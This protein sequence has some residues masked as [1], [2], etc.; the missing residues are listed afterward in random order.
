VNFFPEKEARPISIPT[1]Q[2]EVCSFFTVAHADLIGSKRRKEIVFPRHIAMFLCQELT[3]SSLPQIGKA[4][5]GKD[6]TT[7]MHAVDKIKQKIETET[8]I[9]DQV[10][11]LTKALKNKNR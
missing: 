10:Q 6:H 2:K 11:Y 4:F 1:I 3:D 5:G 8:E 7:V 9:Y